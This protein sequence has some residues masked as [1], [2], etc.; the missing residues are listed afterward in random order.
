[1]NNLAIVLKK[2]RDEEAR[3]ART[4]PQTVF[5]DDGTDQS[6]GGG[7]S[8]TLPQATETTLGG[9]KAKPRT[10]ETTEVAIDAATS[11]LFVEVPAGAS[12]SIDYGSIANAVDMLL[13]Y[14][15]LT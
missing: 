3:L 10:T 9:I 15:G 12:G 4:S 5:N 6:W 7:S 13:D 11:K 2:K 14:G 8:Y 1:M